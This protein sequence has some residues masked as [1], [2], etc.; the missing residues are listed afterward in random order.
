MFCKNI[1]SCYRIP[2]QGGSQGPNSGRTFISKCSYFISFLPYRVMK[3]RK[4]FFKNRVV[5]ALS[6]L[7]LYVVV[8]ST[9]SSF[10][11]GNTAP[12]TTGEGTR[13]NLN[14]CCLNLIFFF[15]TFILDTSHSNLSSQRVYWRQQLQNIMIPRKK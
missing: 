14:S 8:A 7:T 2:H 5:T 9:Y 4:R 15:L 11:N 10:A 12:K 6:L 1:W 13:I 3:S